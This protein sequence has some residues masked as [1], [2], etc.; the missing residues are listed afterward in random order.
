MSH[1]P[2]DRAPRP[3]SSA[4]RAVSQ[5]RTPC[6]HSARIWRLSRRRR[7]RVSRTA[8]PVMCRG[9]GGVKREAR[10]SR[11][12]NA[13][14]RDGGQVRRALDDDRSATRPDRYMRCIG[15]TCARASGQSVGALAASLSQRGR[16]GSDASGRAGFRSGRPASVWCVDRR[17]PASRDLGERPQRHARLLPTVRLQSEGPVAEAPG[18]GGERPRAASTVPLPVRRA[19]GG[20]V[21]RLLRASPARFTCAAVGRW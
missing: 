18:C 6:G 2:V 5:S 8:R 13:S 4:P 17:A 16:S 9:N 7:R 15:T 1:P 20:S 14:G 11:I 12:Q 10:R 3:D 19:W 21:L